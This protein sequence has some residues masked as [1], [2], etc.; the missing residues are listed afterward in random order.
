M[1]DKF[2]VGI[3]WSRRATLA[4]RNVWH[5]DDLGREAFRQLSSQTRAVVRVV[6]GLC[7]S[8]GTVFDPVS[9]HLMWS[10]H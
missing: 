6:G 2:I 7:Y 9:E 10:H 3:V 8:T 4:T 5:F 1:R